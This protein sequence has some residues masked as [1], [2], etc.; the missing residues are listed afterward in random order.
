MRRGPLA[1]ETER[2]HCHCPLHH[3]DCE[4]YGT[5]N[6]WVLRTCCGPFCYERPVLFSFQNRLEICD[7]VGVLVDVEAKGG[8]HGCSIMTSPL[9]LGVEMT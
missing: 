2:E 4:H 6:G 5:D 9:V 7:R 8:R 3:N 1:S